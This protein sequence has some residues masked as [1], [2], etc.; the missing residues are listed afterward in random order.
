[1]LDAT[2]SRL[3]NI[4]TVTI[5][6]DGIAIEGFS[7]ENGTCRDVAALALVWAIRQLS[8]ELQTTMERPGSGNASVG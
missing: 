1:M 6:K 5:A 2:P 7:A 4:G 3:T 8:R